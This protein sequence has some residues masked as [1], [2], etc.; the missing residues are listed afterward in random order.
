MPE[1]E[2]EAV[3]FATD[4]TRL[5]PGEQPASRSLADAQHWIET[6]TQLRETKRDLIANLKE[7]MARQSQEA[8]DEL[9]RSDVRVLE[10]QVSR[11][12]RRL[13]FWQGRLAE[14]D[15]NRGTGE[16]EHSKRESE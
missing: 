5:L 1:E 10:L 12:E 2:Q 15:G 6:Y 14:L 4:E 8:Q 11:F 7:M 13:A 3:R 16:A 9:E